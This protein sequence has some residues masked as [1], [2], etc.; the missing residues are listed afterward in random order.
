MSSHNYD[1]VGS[2]T[3]NTFSN[4]S[5]PANQTLKT[6]GAEVS[7]FFAIVVADPMPDEKS[8]QLQ[9]Q[10]VREK[11]RT[12]QPIE[13]ITIFQTIFWLKILKT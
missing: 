4:L 12:Y 9:F 3:Q 8:F 6:Y 7:H 11:F 2:R 13:I 1:R 10:I 5:R